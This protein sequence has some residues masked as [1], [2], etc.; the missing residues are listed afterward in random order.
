MPSEPPTVKNW[1]KYI[2]NELTGFYPEK[3]GSSLSQYILE[4]LLSV[5]KPVL[6][7]ISHQ[8]IDKSTGSKIKY[9]VSE[10]KKEKPIQYIL[11]KT[12]FY[13]CTIRV[14]PGVLIPR[15]ETEELVQWI[16]NDYKGKEITILD[17]GTGSGCIAIALAKNLKGSTIYATDH[18]DICLETAGK[19]AALNSIHINLIQHD[20]LSE[21]II[22]GI[23]KLDIL[24]SNPPYITESEKNAMRSNVIKYEPPE[25]LF[26]PDNNPLI[27]Y[28]GILTTARLKLKEKGSLYL[29]INENM[30]GK[31]HTLLERNGFSNIILRKDINGKD[32][33]VKAQLV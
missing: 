5:S 30:F 9:I 23:P 31:I 13:G 16:I 10:L 20:V 17:V 33:M 29:E 3:E 26:V 11:G 18:S 6:F 12:Q 32:R 2:R 25:A 15:P 28:H 24:A 21:N 19:N 8:T 4:E 27:Y 7:S 22:P 1:L 14:R